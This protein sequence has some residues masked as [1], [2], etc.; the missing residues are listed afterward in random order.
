LHGGQRRKRVEPTEDSSGSR[1]WV[2]GSLH[3]TPVLFCGFLDLPMLQTESDQAFGI[4]LCC[5]DRDL[6][7]GRP[8]REGQ[9][10]QRQQM[11]EPDGAGEQK[12]HDNLA[13]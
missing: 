12:P 5:G 7:P 2:I 11:P 4:S 13:Y 9:R 6:V 1:F 8:S 3:G 10:Q